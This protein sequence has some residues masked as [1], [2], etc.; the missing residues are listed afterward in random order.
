MNFA[1]I[2]RSTST[3]LSF[4]SF[5]I[6]SIGVWGQS[7]FS[8][9]FQN[10][11]IEIPANIQKLENNV[12]SLPSQFG[13][14]FFAWVQFQ[15]IPTQVQQNTIKTSG[16]ELMNYISNRTYL[17]S[18][19]DV[20]A[21]QMLIENGA[22]GFIPVLPELKTTERLWNG[23]MNAWAI[24]G[25]KV[26]LTLVVYADISTD[27][28]INQLNS[29]SVQI[30]EHFREFSVFEIQIDQDK[31][32]DL[33]NLGFVKW[34]EEIPAPA[35]QE[36]NRGRNLHRASGLDTQTPTGRNYTGEGVGVLVR[37]D[38]II[39]P[40]I[41]FQGRI[42]NS[43][44]TGTGQ[45][46]GDGVAG[47]LTGAGNLDPNMR[48]MAAGANLYVSNYASSFL[49]NA[50]TSRI[51]NGTVQITNSSYGDGCNDG[52]TNNS[53]NVDDQ[54]YDNPNLLHVFSC[55]NS[56]TSDCGYG[57]GSG[58]GNITGGHKMGKNVIA[59]ANLF[60]DGTL[61]TSSSRGPAYDG[62]IKPD[63]AANGQNQM[64]TD[65]NN[66]YQTFGGTSG[67]SPGIAGVSAQLYQAYMEA[68]SGQLPPAAL[69]KAALLN[70][71]N[72]A[73]NVGPDFKFGWGIVN[74]LRAGMLIEEGRYLSG[75]AT[76]GVSANHSITI[77]AG[78]KQVR[79]ML[80]WADPAA[81]NGASIAL[82]N[83][84]DLVVTNPA[85]TNFLPWVLNSTPNG[86]ALNSPATTGVDH[87]NNMEQVLISNPSAGT[88]TIQVNGFAVPMGPQTYYI[89]YELISDEITVTYP[90]MGEH[91]VPGETESIHW[92]A[93]E[94]S[95]N[96]NLEYS[97]NNGSSWNTI[98][99][100]NGNLR[101]FQW[102]IPSTLSSTGS[103]LIRV[104]RGSVSD[105]SDS[106]FS[107]APLV[108]GQAIT[109]VCPT[110]VTFSWNAVPNANEYDVYA[111]GAEYM[112][113]IGSSNSTSFLHT[114][115]NPNTPIW[116]AIVAKNNLAN[117]QSRRTI[118]SYYPGGLLN[119]AIPTDIQVV[120]VENTGSDFSALCHPNGG[121]PKIKLINSGTNAIS[122]FML[123]YQLSGQN[124][125]SEVYS[126]TLNPGQQ[127][128]YTF[129]TPLSISSSG[130]FTLTCSAVLTGDGD[131]SNNQ[132]VLNFYS[133]GTSNSTP[134][135][136]TFEGGGFLP[137][138]WS[139]VNTDNDETWEE[140]T[141]ITG[142]NGSSTSAAYINN[143]SYN[144]SGEEDYFE[145]GFYALAGGSATLSFD[146]AKAQYSNSFNDSLA[147]QISADCGATYT[148]IYAKG[149][150]TLAT[151]A[152]QT[153]TFN[154]NSASNWRNEVIDI[155]S[156]LGENVV[157]RFINITGYSNS[158]YI[159]NINISSDL[160]LTDNTDASF[161]LFP[162]PSQDV[163]Y[164]RTNNHLMLG[165]K[166]ILTNQ[167]GQ[168]ILVLDNSNIVND[169][170]EI[171]LANFAR[172]IYFVS[173]I[174]NGTSSTHRLVKN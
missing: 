78:T 33:A 167:M 140:V 23:D 172:G 90:N 26:K 161:T 49:D 130:N 120:S 9:E 128:I 155:S 62:R 45:S 86:I 125:V 163:I 153:G 56:G 29:I 34:F 113:V 171:N 28:I 136:E 122:N 63:I 119:C 116:Y 65:E 58:W 8:F 115:T 94:S 134:F 4:F 13:N 35:E 89:V 14:Q 165:S 88:Y 16:I 118:A 123:N 98:S 112:E 93:H 160:S 158:T 77:P 168:E 124:L 38:G 143:Y 145:T 32:K 138:A 144:A 99:S 109:Q 30:T 48:G 74:A 97:T 106:V 174:H 141:G 64:S 22:R 52:Y 133:Q 67:A 41:D 104:T 110:V 84:L 102:A 57:A 159:D 3:F 71:A 92:D 61:A 42:D 96:F 53:V 142:S 17:V 40:H 10:K 20:N 135:V 25:S 82:I 70:T 101:T 164:L 21:K 111:L 150:S 166:I 121:F 50:T 152:N 69:V 132:Q 117:W 54:M 129:T 27:Q 107:I 24:V 75:T 19:T 87:L 18:W 12:E 80:Y 95:G 139:L 55:G 47:I 83:D 91:F 85:N 100:V 2:L 126:G 1:S 15:Q 60:F 59:T 162:N 11:K 108:T 103:G 137:A 6:L 73:G 37:D 149:G 76:Q 72:D 131:P 147:V 156:Y 39:G 7:D 68:H 36:D 66:D 5:L 127:I 148:T 173:L 105:V 157:C 81:S 31:I 114:I 170:I 154:P 151:V 169:E 43:T 44:A 51:A 79:F 46:H 146:L